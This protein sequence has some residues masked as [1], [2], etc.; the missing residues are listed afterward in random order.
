MFSGE[1]FLKKKIVTIEGGTMGKDAHPLAI[2]VNQL[3]K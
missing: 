1:T 3:L 2:S